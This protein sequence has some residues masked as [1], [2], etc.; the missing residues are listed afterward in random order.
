MV[1][2]I[3]GEK[4]VRKNH[5]I[6]DGLE[7]CDYSFLCMTGALTPCGLEYRDGDD[8][9]DWTTDGLIIG[10]LDAPDRVP[11]GG[12]E[13]IDLPIMHG[14]FAQVVERDRL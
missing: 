5:Q 7:Y 11:A 6:V 1:R 12:M 13:F 4:I 2:E 14:I 10:A 9:I 8:W 3:I